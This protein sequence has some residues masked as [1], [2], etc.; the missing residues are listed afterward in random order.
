MSEL[1]KLQADLLALFPSF[2]GIFGPRA[3]PNLDKTVHE[4]AE[5]LWVD[6]IRRSA[7]RRRPGYS[8]DRR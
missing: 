2:T 6:E 5:K 4:N 7:H 8:G 3:N 1:E